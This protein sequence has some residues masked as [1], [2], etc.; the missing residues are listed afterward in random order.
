[1]MISLLALWPPD[2][3][4]SESEKNGMYCEGRSAIKVVSSL[5]AGRALVPYDIGG[6]TRG[7]CGSGCNGAPGCWGGLCSSGGGTA[8]IALF[9]GSAPIIWT[10]A[11]DSQIVK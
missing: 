11:D 6:S 5:K 4:D 2:E 3:P 7:F 8:A 9:S 1:M 10:A